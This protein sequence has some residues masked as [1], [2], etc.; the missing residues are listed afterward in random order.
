VERWDRL[1]NFQ[2][3]LNSFH[4]SAQCQRGL[5][6]WLPPLCSLW[7]LADLTV[8]GLCQADDNKLNSADSLLLW[9]PQGKQALPSL[10][11]AGIPS[12]DPD[13]A[14][15]ECFC[16]SPYASPA[17]V[18]STHASANINV[19]AAC[20]VPVIAISFSYL[21]IATEQLCPL[22]RRRLSSSLL[23]SAAPLR[24]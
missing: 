2:A 18:F 13:D 11:A 21:P 23:T 14:P 3:T 22:E 8:P 12:S 7:A 1:A 5:E 20:I 10:S 9:E 16:C 19:I 15:D 6:K 4:I 17:S 24:C